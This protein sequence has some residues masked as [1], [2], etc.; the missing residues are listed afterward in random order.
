MNLLANRL[1]IATRGVAI[2]GLSPYFHLLRKWDVAHAAAGGLA[3]KAIGL[4]GNAVHVEPLD[5]GA[6]S[7]CG[8]GGGV[9]HAIPPRRLEWRRTPPMA[10]DSCQH[11][12]PPFKDFGT[13]HPPYP[14]RALRA[15]P[16]RPRNRGRSRPS[17]PGPRRGRRQSGRS[18]SYE[19]TRGGTSDVAREPAAHPRRRA[20]AGPR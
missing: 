20:G 11:R 4:D 16:C 10:Q 1:P 7:R 2:A 17:G 8:T 12:G 15:R 9:L 6:R 19:S 18:T 14:P 3:Q 13:R 5:A